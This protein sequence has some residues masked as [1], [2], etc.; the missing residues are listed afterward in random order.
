MYPILPKSFLPC[1]EPSGSSAS[2][3]TPSGRPVLFAGMLKIIQWVNVPIGASGSSIKIAIDFVLSG[4]FSQ[5]SGIDT[6]SPKPVY[7]TG[8]VSPFLKAGLLIII[9]SVTLFT[10]PFAHPDKIIVVS[11]AIIKITFT[12][13]LYYI[14]F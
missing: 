4:M 8:I 2:W 9:V 5:F 7:F 12:F 3:G 6:S 13:I 11:A 14:T 1:L 10:P